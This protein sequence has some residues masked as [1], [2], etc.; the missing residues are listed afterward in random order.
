[1]SIS[2]ILN[3]M[4]LPDEIINY[5]FM[6]MKSPTNDIIKQYFKDIKSF[7]RSNI[8]A[9]YILQLNKQYNYIWFNYKRFHNAFFYE[10][11]ECGIMLDVEEYNLAPR[12]H[13]NNHYHF[14]S[15][16]YDNVYYR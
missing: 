14:C 5:I 4:Y 7:E 10:C 11:D 15:Y 2:K 6:Y 16:C 9:C 12:C 13:L 3:D 8:N 1:M